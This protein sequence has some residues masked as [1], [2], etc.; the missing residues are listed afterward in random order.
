MK[1]KIT[2]IITAHHLHVVPE[3]LYY[4]QRVTTKINVYKA[5]SRLYKTHKFHVDC[6]SSKFLQKLEYND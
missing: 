3:L 6:T 5:C 4:V 2:F 1:W